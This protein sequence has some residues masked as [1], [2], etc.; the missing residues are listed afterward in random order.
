M[1]FKEHLGQLTESSLS[2]IYNQAKEHDS[3]TI[4]AFRSKRDC[5]TGEVYTKKE[6]LARSKTLKRDLLALGYGVTKIAG[7]YIENYGTKNAIE[8]KEESYIV[9]DLKD[10]NNLLA[11]LKKLGLKYEQDSVTFQKLND[12]YQLVGT[13]KCPDGYPGYGKKVKLGKPIYGKD[14]EFHS[15]VNGRPFVF[16]SIISPLEK[17]TDYFPTEIRSILGN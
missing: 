3:G 5:N 13:N 17:L 9:I 8:V 2:R 1:T 7:T 6:N 15:K 11:D 4:S 14:G 12:T 10:Q 16:E